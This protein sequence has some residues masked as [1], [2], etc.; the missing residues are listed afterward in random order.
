MVKL[1]TNDE[2]LLIKKS[3]IN[4]EFADIFSHNLWILVNSL[5]S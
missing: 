2:F 4:T 5:K 1:K 3:I